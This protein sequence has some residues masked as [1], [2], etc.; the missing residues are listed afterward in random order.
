MVTARIP[1]G[2]PSDDRSPALRA[3]ARRPSRIKLRPLAAVAGLL[4]ALAVHTFAA[5]DQPPTTA[6]DILILNSYAPGYEWSDD[7]LA[8]VVSALRSFH[9]GIE[10]V[11][12]YLDFKRF[13]GHEREAALLQD[14]AAKCRQR[15]PQLIVTLDNAAFDFALAHRAQLGPEAPLVFG[16]LNRFT[17]E[18]IAGQPAITGVSEET[19]FSG[20][21]QLIASLRP[22]A[23]RIVVLGN[24]TESSTEK[25]RALEA[26]LPRYADRYTFEFFEDWTNEQ[27]FARVARLGEDEVGLVLDLTRD[28]TGRDN[29]RDGSFT[30][31]IVAR[32]RSPLFLTSRP[33]GAN[34][35]SRYQ[36]DGIGGGMVVASAHGE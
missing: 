7:E 4:G 12:Q 29:Y 35:W 1:S 25:R 31:T 19:D 2:H 26:F 6:P 17:P 15:P 34:D 33:P 22:E 18:M 8:G 14:V 9:A 5:A 24:S 10:P 13:P 3:P 36:W 27:L 16:G 30:E 11:I 20:T 23:R 32:S 28:S 21:F